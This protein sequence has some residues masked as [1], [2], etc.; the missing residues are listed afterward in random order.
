V[1]TGAGVTT[2]LSEA[3]L[4]TSGDGDGGDLISISGAWDF[5]EVWS[6]T[7][8]EDIQ[9]EILLDDGTVLSTAAGDILIEYTGDAVAV[10]DIAGAGDTGP[11]G[12]IDIVDWLRLRG[13][14][15]TNVSSLSLAE[16]YLRGD[17]NGDLAIDANDYILFVS[18]YDAANGMGAFQAMVA[19]VPE[20]T[21]GVLAAFGMGLVVFRKSRN[22]RAA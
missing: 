14:V 7:P 13:N 11:D 16:A 12:T 10:G 4:A 3:V 9:L 20:P 17:L 19:Q 22:R 15:G 2:D 18:A 8:F 6:R 21:A 5:G 1:L